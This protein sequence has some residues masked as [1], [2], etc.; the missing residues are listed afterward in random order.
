VVGGFAFVLKKT[1]GLGGAVGLGAAATIFLGMIEAPLLV[2]PCLMRMTRTEL[3]IL[4]T[5]GLASVAGTVFVLYATILTPVVPGA[6]GHILVA[7]MMGLPAAVMIAWLMVP[8]P[9]ATAAQAADLGFRSGM[10]AIARG[11]ED[12]L[13]IYLQIIALL[14]VML[15]L[16]ALA[17]R[18]L[19]LLPAVAGAPVTL[20]RILGVLFAPMVWLYGVP[21]HEARAAG[22]LMGT[23]T[24][25][26]ELVAYLNFAALPKGSFD[27]RTTLIMVYGLCG[28]AN[29][30]SVG[31]LIAGMS[32]LMP[33][34]RAEIVPLALKSLV[35]GTMASGLTACMIGILY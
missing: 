35:S 24:V 1:L 31:I 10:D 11:T 2:R 30:G 29:L 26:N 3:F 16:V 21:W 9:A 23:K 18:L 4:F 22:A 20:E 28:F 15:A 27:P 6:L 32:A 19:A 8:G 5:V 33:E 34:R 14:I 13:R 12:G 25:L 17:D 7:S